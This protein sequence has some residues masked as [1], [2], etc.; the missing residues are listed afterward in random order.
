L[1]RPMARCAASSTGFRAA[2]ALALAARA[3][4][5]ERQGPGRDRVRRRSL[6]SSMAARRSSTAAARSRPGPRGH[7]HG[8]LLLPDGGVH[9][10]ALDRRR[11][12]S[13]SR[14]M[15]RCA[16]RVASSSLVEAPAAALRQLARLV[17]RLGEG[18]PRARP[19]RAPGRRRSPP[20]APPGLSRCRA[21]PRSAPRVAGRRVKA[22][23][24]DGPEPDGAEPEH[25][26]V[27][28][29]RRR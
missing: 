15:A 26:Q 2:G 20:G 10:D 13:A 16:R 25:R 18:R 27:V 17:L 5:R 22:G 4:Q 29:R 1:P 7:V 23:G 8:D 21:C 12:P 9:V 19:A 6:T 28:Q 14:G 3:Q 11:E 24:Q